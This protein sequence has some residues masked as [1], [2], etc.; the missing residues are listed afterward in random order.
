MVQSQGLVSGV[1][2]VQ[3]RGRG[4]P[5]LGSAGSGSAGSV[6]L[7]SFGVGGIGESIFTPALGVSGSGCCR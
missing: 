1:G 7:R 5:S 4:E 3:R 6:S 2:D